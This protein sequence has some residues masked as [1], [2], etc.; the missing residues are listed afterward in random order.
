MPGS[1]TKEVKWED[2][3]VGD[4]VK[5]EKDKEFPADLLL[6][7]AAKGKDIVYVDTMNLDGETNLKEKYCFAK[8]V[9]PTL[10]TSANAQGYLQCDP[11]HESLEEWDGNIH[12]HSGE[13]FNAK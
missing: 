7:S 9:L 8:S 4:I 10:E 12:F 11:P 13:V 6:L 1:V 3:K 5:I 2:I